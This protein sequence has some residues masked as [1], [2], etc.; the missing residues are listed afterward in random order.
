MNAPTIQPVDFEKR[1]DQYVQVR[2]KIAAIKERHKEELQPW[3]DCL[4][5]LNDMLLGHLNNIGADNVGTKAG[6]VYRT[7][8]KSATIADKAAFWSYVVTTGKW[9]LID[10]KANASQVSAHINEL[11]EQA[12][13]DP[14]VQPGPPPGIN[15][16][17]T[18][19]AGVQRK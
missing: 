19:I 6:T 3:N 13:T 10:Y 1:V 11:A 8:K 2:D 5:Q 16:S 9:D 18:Y 17:I 14:T 7:P 4:E 12:K 15:Y